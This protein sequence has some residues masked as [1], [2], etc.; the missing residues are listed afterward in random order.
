M[1]RP[2]PSSTRSAT[3]CPYT[4]L[5]R[6]VRIRAVQL[7]LIPS[8]RAQRSNPDNLCFLPISGLPQPLRGFAMTDHGNEAPIFLHTT[9]RARLGRCLP[10]SEA[11]TSDL[12]SLM[13]ISYAVF[14][15]KKKNTQ[16]YDY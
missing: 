4:T 12:Q 14:F 2:P 11:H 6:S 10:R 1:I 9:I 3:L 13:R 7:T 8:L 5:F 16:Q 15:L